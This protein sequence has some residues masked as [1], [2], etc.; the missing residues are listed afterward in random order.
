[1]TC[2]QYFTQSRSHYVDWGAKVKVDHLELKRGSYMDAA[3]EK[4]TAP[5]RQAVNLD[6]LSGANATATTESAK[7]Q[8]PDVRL[9]RRDGDEVSVLTMLTDTS[10][11][12]LHATRMSSL[13]RIPSTLDIIAAKNR[14]S[15][16]DLLVDLLP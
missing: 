1:M 5:S 11:P 10:V 12:A 4:T 7:Y 9:L 15:S 14:S 8:P 3:P 16:V 13:R 2:R 6:L